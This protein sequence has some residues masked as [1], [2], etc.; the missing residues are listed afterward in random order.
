MRFRISIRTASEC[1]LEFHLL[2][3]GFSR[4]AAIPDAAAGGSSYGAAVAFLYLKVVG[5]AARSAHKLRLP[6]HCDAKW[7][8]RDPERRRAGTG[9]L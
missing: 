5:A 1:T 4:H 6:G 3:G 7:R 9:F 8:C 2:A